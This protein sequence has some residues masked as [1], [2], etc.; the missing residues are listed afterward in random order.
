MYNKYSISKKILFVIA[1][2]VLVQCTFFGHLSNGLDPSWNFALNYINFKGKKFGQ[3]HFFTYGPLG[4]LGQCQFVGNN[5]YIGIIFWLLLTILQ[6]YL[7][8]Q[9][10]SKVD[11]VLFLSIAVILI[12][13]SA[14]IRGADTY[15]CYLYTLSM[16]LTYKYYNTWSAV[17]TLFF[18][19]IIFLFK[20]SGTMLLVGTILMLISSSVYLK[21]PKKMMLFFISNMLIGPICYL[22]Y[23]PSVKSLMQYIKAAVE[24]TSGYNMYMTVQEYQAYLIWV[25]LLMFCYLC[26][27]IYGIYKN[28]P[29]WDVLLILAPSCFI[30][31]KQG[32]VR[33]DGHYV[34]AII[35]LLLVGSLLFLFIDW[36]DWICKDKKFISKMMLCILCIFVIVPI[37]GRGQTLSAAIQQST[38]NIFNF[39]KLIDDCIHQDFN[40]LKEHNA[41]FMDIIDQDTY[42]TFPW[43]ITENI[44]YENDQFMIPP[45]IQN[46]TVYTPYLD[47]LN[48]KFYEGS[49]AP[50]YIIMYLSTI[51]GRWP[52][53]EAPKTWEKIYQNYFVLTTDEEKYLLRK[54][55][56]ALTNEVYECDSMSC[57][58]SEEI[59]IPLN[60]RYIKIN[61]KLGL[62][63]RLEKL[64]YK[65]LPVNLRVTYS[66]GTVKNGRVV[67]KNL[68]EG[69]FN[70]DSLIWDG[71]DY[72]KYMNQLERDKEVTSIALSGEGIKQYDKEMEITFYK[73]K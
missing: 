11:N 4:F 39:P 23:C 38:F 8:R 35:G 25:I 18:S 55:E 13:F 21:K 60:C 73:S 47:K 48:A 72:V 65:I 17:I 54:R 56:S 61:A 43:E 42:T 15:I 33:N 16:L 63:G 31:Y 10:F 64:F 30:W 59:E 22:F 50:E 34:S 45:L 70:I 41:A 67:L 71:E 68:E 12:I 2:L 6:I 44:S 69:D 66:D 5:H 20:F 29:G 40:S 27:L 52:L 53:I 28:K 14:P 49:E 7:L 58:I 46:Y 9:I 51:D 1:N 24:I 19:G 57:Q 37:M 36:R 3:D 26:L 62:K 32:F